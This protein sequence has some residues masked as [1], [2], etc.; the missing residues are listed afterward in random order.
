MTTK[1]E[2]IDTARKGNFSC[3]RMGS[4]LACNSC[5]C[6]DFEGKHKDDCPVGALLQLIQDNVSE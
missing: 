2:L 1:K 6:Y 5:G 4:E 3:C